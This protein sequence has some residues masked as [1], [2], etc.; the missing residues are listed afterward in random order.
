ML[1]DMPTTRGRVP[2]QKARS[3]GRAL[4]QERVPDGSVLVTSQWCAQEGAGEPAR[5]PWP[6]HRQHS[7]GSS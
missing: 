2:V 5:T 7:Q 1:G 6:P 3:G 4:K